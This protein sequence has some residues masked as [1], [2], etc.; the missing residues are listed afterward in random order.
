MGVVRV[1]FITALVSTVRV[2]G[3][4]RVCGALRVRETVDLKA[5]PTIAA[6]LKTNYKLYAR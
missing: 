4:L 5:Y 6:T 1:F 3:A 2:R